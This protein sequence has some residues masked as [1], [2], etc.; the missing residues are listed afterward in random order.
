[1][2]FRTES[3]SL[4]EACSLDSITG[5]YHTEHCTVRML[6]GLWRWRLKPSSRERSLKTGRMVYGLVPL[7]FSAK[8]WL[9]PFLYLAISDALITKSS[10][11]VGNI[12][13]LL[14]IF[15]NCGGAEISHWVSFAPQAQIF[16]GLQGLQQHFAC[17]RISALIPQCILYIAY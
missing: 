2:L 5:Y 3:K 14:E 4:E 17:D 12:Q 15:G 6:G 11:I 7:S 16:I 10:G 1:M 8:P 13:V 9:G